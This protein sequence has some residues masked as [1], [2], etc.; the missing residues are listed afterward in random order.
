MIFSVYHHGAKRYDYYEDGRTEGTHAGAP[1]I[2]A[3]GKIGVIPEA[4][5]WRLPLTAKKIGSGEI[6][7]GRIA[8]RGGG[9]LAGIE[10]APT[11]V[12]IGAVLGYLAYRAWRKKR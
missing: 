6:P 2:L 12:A 9:P 10:L 1:T 11:T 5:A 3:T 8:S 7:R 4:A